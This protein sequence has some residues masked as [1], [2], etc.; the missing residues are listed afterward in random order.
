MDPAVQLV[1]ISSVK[2]ALGAFVEK[3]LAENGRI[4][5]HQEGTEI[6]DRVLNNPPDNMHHLFNTLHELIVFQS[7]SPTYDSIMTFL[8]QLPAPPGI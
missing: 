8:A 7:N 1:A 4:I 6:V 2:R 5:S 3:I